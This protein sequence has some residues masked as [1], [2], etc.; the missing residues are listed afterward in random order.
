[1]I[2][3]PVAYDFKIENPPEAVVLTK[4]ISRDSATFEWTVKG[5]DPAAR[6]RRFAY[7]LYPR[8]KD[9]SEFA[10]VA[11]KE[12]KG[13]PRGH[14]LFQV[15]ARD[16]AENQETAEEFAFEVHGGEAPK[17]R[18]L[19]RIPDVLESDE[20][21]IEFIG[22]SSRTPADKLDVIGNNF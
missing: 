22:E 10:P 21:T 13:L 6:N 1:N 3:A 20:V 2:S 19:S 7:R 12:Y 5:A 16:V 15:R 9:W 4:N 18:I 11:R 8:E 14:Y 17:T